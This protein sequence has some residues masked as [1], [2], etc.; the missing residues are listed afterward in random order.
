MEEP[1]T[2]LVIPAQG[3]TLSTSPAISAIA[4]YVTL[5]GHIMKDGAHAHGQDA[6]RASLDFILRRSIDGFVNQLRSDPDGPAILRSILREAEK[7]GVDVTEI[8]LGIPTV[9]YS[10]HIR[11]RVR[12]FEQYGMQNANL[13]A[14]V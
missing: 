11:E 2:V 10:P 7:S 14:S 3:V 1:K 12:L 13:V 6:M 5:Q 9:P 8:K 4:Q